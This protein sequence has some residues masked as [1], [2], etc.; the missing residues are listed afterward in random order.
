MSA[1]E[2]PLTRRKP[3]DDVKTRFGFYDLGLAY[4]LTGYWV[5]GI[6]RAGGMNLILALM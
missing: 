1:S 3:E 4:R 6:R 5:S 2:S